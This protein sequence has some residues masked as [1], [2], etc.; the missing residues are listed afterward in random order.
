MAVTFFNV[1][2]E[3]QSQ[4]IQFVDLSGVGSGP[5]AIEGIKDEHIVIELVPLIHSGKER[6]NNALTPGVVIVPGHSIRSD[7]SSGENNRDDIDLPISI[8]IV[9]RELSTGNIDR[10]H[11]VLK[12]E[13]NIRQ[14]FNN[15]N[16]RKEVFDSDGYVDLVYIPSVDIVD[17][18]LFGHH[19]QMVMSINL[20]AKSRGARS[21]EGSI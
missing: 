16:L 13:Q 14:H 15:Q 8:Q 17:E 21:A 7:P 1:L 3:V 11:A 19:H 9:D 12:W 5:N 4:I 20:I 10:I 2:L 6:R 18:R